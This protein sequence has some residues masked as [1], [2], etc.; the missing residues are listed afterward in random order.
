MAG[1]FTPIY[2]YYLD[3]QRTRAETQKLQTDTTLDRVKGLIDIYALS[4]EMQE[5]QIA[6]QVWGQQTQGQMRQP[7]VFDPEAVGSSQ[8]DANPSTGD[9]PSLQM[10]ARMDAMA[11]ALAPV[12]PQ[13]SMEWATKASTIRDQLY[14][15]RTKQLE[16]Q[17]KQTDEIASL[18][19]SIQPGDQTGY[20]D[21]L[22]KL[23]DSGVD[24]RA[25]GLTGNLDADT[26]AL[27]R[28]AQQSMTYSQKLEAQHKAWDENQRTAE[29]ADRVRHEGQ[30]EAIG[31][32]KVG[33]A[34]AGESLRASH[35]KI[36]ENYRAKED[37]RASAGVVRN[38][39]LDVQR[40]RDMVMR[41]DPAGNDGKYADSLVAADPGL[42]QLSQ[43]QKKAASAEIQIIA[44]RKLADKITKPSD[45]LPS[46]DDF[47]TALHN[48]TA[49]VSKRVTKGAGFF[50]KPSLA[51]AIYSPAELATKSVGDK[52]SIR[53]KTYEVTKAGTKGDGSD[54][55]LSE[56]K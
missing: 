3:A 28:L 17:K 19:G 45:S 31:W 16:I 46:S 41:P 33:V 20:T 18:F 26:P 55:E 21:S 53:G 7:G 50:G 5:Q 22:M 56:V 27:K 13:K 4:K 43:S 12:N 8:P 34:Q 35:D 36:M 1:G 38:D 23:H 32:A 29:F 54:V 47:L 48:A 30:D 24:I 15:R 51:T 49:S 6:R 52:V 40:M 39:K 14:T 44:R 42:S 9:D 10:A 37:A 2:Q 25:F 11:K